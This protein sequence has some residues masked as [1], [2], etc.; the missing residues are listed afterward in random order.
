MIFFTIINYLKY[1]YKRN[2]EN[3]KTEKNYLIN[4]N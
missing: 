1:L 4:I 2:N 3:L